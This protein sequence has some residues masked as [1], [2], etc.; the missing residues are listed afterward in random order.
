MPDLVWMLIPVGLLPVAAVS[1]WIAARRSQRGT[2]AANSSA[3]LQAD[4]FKGINY[5]LNEQPD[6]AIEAFIKVLEVDSETVE[7][8]LALGNLYRRRGEVDR[9]IR[10]HQNL[11]ARPTLSGAQ[12]IEALFE[13]GADYMSAGLLDRAENLFQELCE[14][15]TFGVKALRQVVEIY[16]QQKDWDEAIAAAKKLDLA[17]GETQAS[18]IAH[19]YCEKADLA[20]QSRQAGA[21]LDAARRALG[22]HPACVRA[23]LLEGEIH[24]HDARYDAAIDAYKRVEQQ[25]PE[26]LPEVIQS[27]SRCYDKV[28]RGQE[29]MQYLGHLMKRYDGISVTLALAGM[30]RL[31]GGPREAIA[32]ITQNLRSRPSVRALDRLLELELE[33]VADAPPE[34]LL[35]LKRLTTEL[36]ENRTDYKCGHC[37]FPAKFLHWQCPACKHWSTIKPIQGVEGE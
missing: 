1:G 24:F 25:D 5:L 34:H 27:L 32:F 23:S 31:K 22:C 11:I 2:A 13:L 12:R 18:V 28:G 19:Y 10:I 4:Y 6:K 26:F 20:W 36:L 9:A 35:I 21:A 15:G 29:M 14:T 16:E 30:K 7:T 8:H 33:T 3:G 37:G 17:T